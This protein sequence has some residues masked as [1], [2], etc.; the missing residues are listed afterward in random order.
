MKVFSRV[1]KNTRKYWMRNKDN[2]PKPRAASSPQ[3][4]KKMRKD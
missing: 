3:L 4:K 1:C 2:Q